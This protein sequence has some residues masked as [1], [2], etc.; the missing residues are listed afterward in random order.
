MEHVDF[1]KWRLPKWILP[2]HTCTLHV[3]LLQSVAEEVVREIR[4]RR[5]K[6]C[7]V[8]VLKT[9]QSSPECPCDTKST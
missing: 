5:R 8:A 3:I 4:N 7:T 1:T 2:D 9:E 6:Q